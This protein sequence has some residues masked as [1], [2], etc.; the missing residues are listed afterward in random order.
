MNLR[1]RKLN[2]SLEKLLCAFFDHPACALQLFYFNDKLPDGTYGPKY[3]GFLCVK[4]Y[5]KVTTAVWLD[6]LLPKE[7]TD[8]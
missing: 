2:F 8:V 4:C 7:K 3:P 5:Q 1:Q 6:R